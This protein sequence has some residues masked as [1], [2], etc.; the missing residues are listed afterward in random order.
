MSKNRNNKNNLNYM[1]NQVEEGDFYALQVMVD[2]FGHDTLTVACFKTKQ[3]AG[4]YIN[5]HGSAW[6][7]NK[8]YK[9]VPQHWNTEY[10]ETW[11]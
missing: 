8:V 2:G 6:W 11:D 3:E 1:L 4:N 9:V 7:A 10:D 5:T